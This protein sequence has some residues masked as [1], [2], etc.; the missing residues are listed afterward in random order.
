MNDRL[1][2]MLIYEEHATDPHK[3]KI[4]N[5]FLSKL[6]SYFDNLSYYEPGEC[7]ICMESIGKI[8]YIKT[9]CGHTYHNRCLTKWKN[10]CN[11]CPLCREPLCTCMNCTMIDQLNGKDV[12]EEVQNMIRYMF[13][14]K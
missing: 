11:K 12:P 3:K 8:Q 2:H 5:D 13:S 14:I 9:V 7:S 1:F 4:K 6:D 10:K